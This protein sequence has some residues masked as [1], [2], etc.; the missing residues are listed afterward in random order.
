[1]K[2]EKIILLIYAFAIAAAIPPFSASAQQTRALPVP[3]PEAGSDV[4][5]WGAL[6]Y[7]RRDLLLRPAEKIELRKLEDR[8]LAELR[9]LEDKFD[10]DLWA[11]RQKQSQ[12][13]DG[14]LMKFPVR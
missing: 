8:H 7:S 14:L 10:R 1:M 3:P 4:G 6:P 11:L 2:S 5:N 9:N 13:R 12:E